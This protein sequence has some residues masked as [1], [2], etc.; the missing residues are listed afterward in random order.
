MSV[1]GKFWLLTIPQYLFVPYLPNGCCYIKGQLE[2]GVEGGEEEGYLHWQVIVCLSKKG[3]LGRIQEIFG[4]QLHAELSRSAA[5]STY[6]HKDATAIEGTRFELG[7]MPHKRNDKVDWARVKASAQAGRLDDIDDGVFVQHYGTLKRI[8]ADY[9]DCP[10]VDRQCTIYWGPTATGKSHRARTQ[11]KEISDKV[12]N[13]IPST[14]WWCGYRGES[15]V[16]VD[17]FQGEIG[18]THW[19]RWLDKYGVS[20]EIKGGS[21]PL[22]ASHFWITSNVD[23]KEWWLNPLSGT[24]CTPAQWEA[25]KRRVTIIHVPLRLF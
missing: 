6:V 24:K 18:I 11:A 16:V 9:Q 19:L 10:D 23:P 21:T 3:R 1:Q 25:F 5:A 4:R 7:S 8:A 22:L 2:Q 13:K 12:F 20:V 14:K 15:C 17:E